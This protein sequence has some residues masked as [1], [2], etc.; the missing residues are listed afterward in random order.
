MLE[1]NEQVDDQLQRIIDIRSDKGKVDIEYEL[2]CRKM[3][4]Y[5]SALTSVFRYN[6][7]EYAQHLMEEVKVHE[8]AMHMVGP[9]HFELN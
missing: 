2:W 4:I 5:A 3:G 9:D 7:P 6:D 1:R 8:L